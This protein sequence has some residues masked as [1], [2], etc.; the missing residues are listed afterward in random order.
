MGTPA[1]TTISNRAT[2]TFL[3]TGL[4]APTTVNSNFLNV[5]VAQIAV[6]N[7]SPVSAGA[8]A[9]L[10]TSADYPVTI[11]N[12]GNGTDRFALTTASSLGLIA[13]VYRDVDGDG[14]LSP[15]EL[16][17]GP[18]MQTGDLPAD[19]SA[20]CILRIS[21]PGTVSLIGQTDI[22][23]VTATSLFDASKHAL[24]QRSTS[25]IGAMLAS[26]KSVN[27]AIPRAGDR[28]TYTISSSNNGNGDA[29]NVFVT[30]VLDGNL[31]FVTGAAAPVPDSLSGQRIVWNL[32]SVAAG[33]QNAIVFQA[34]IA[35][36][37]VPGTEVHN[38]AA[39]RYEDGPNARAATSSETG[40]ITIQS[41]GP[42][43][44]DVAPTR[45]GTGEPGDTVQYGF[46]VTNTGALAESFDLSYTS[47]QGI[48]W[49]FSE[50]LNGNGKT[51]PGEP[52]VVSTGL[53]PG[54]GQFSLVAR[55]V[56]PLVPTDLTQDIMNLNVHSTTN[57]TNFRTVTATT[58]IAIPRMTLLKLATAPD[59]RSGNEIVYSIAYS[60]EGHGQAVGFAVTDA[61]PANTAYVPGSVRL[62]GILKTD[63]A[64]GDEVTVSGG[65][66]AVRLGTVMPGANGTIEFHVRIL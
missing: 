53:L 66:V 32:G 27:N 15:A 41:G 13:S 58:T 48:V 21:V 11:T 63:Q 39:L 62:N 12:S 7:V 64:D 61:I 33:G 42:V 20:R 34:D 19:S 60:N 23:T 28:V 57:R 31:R 6:V 3:Y 9:R 56:L 16:A 38:I 50:D 18:I 51:D 36:N 25:I 17:A 47:T 52:A 26:T 29:T 1:G 46:V 22:V 10:H 2:V 40:F 43:T 37:A 24:A 5:I 54:N 45:T 55:A 35:S 65:G 49:T 44:V 59:P 8:T 30:D 14:V 4:P